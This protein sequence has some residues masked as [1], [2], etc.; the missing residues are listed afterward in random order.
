[1][2]G[3]PLTKETFPWWLLRYSHAARIKFELARD[4]STASA[5]V[6]LS[7]RPHIASLK[8]CNSRQG[9]FEEWE[10]RALL[11]ELPKHV[12]PVVELLYP[13]GW[14]LGEVLSLR[15]SQVNFQTGVVC[16]EPG[17]P[18]NDDGREFSFRA[19]PETEALL[20]RQRDGTDQIEHAKGMVVTHVFHKEGKPTKDSRTSWKKACEAAKIVDRRPH[21][22]QRTGS[23][24]RR[25]VVNSGG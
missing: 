25:E 3:R 7:Q 18:K 6:R 24:G 5:N 22:F 12:R 4:L 9:F 17:L 23:D 1:L 20:E 10:Y 13:T 19:W 8:V 21:D 11:V 2:T 15:W 16:L 14:R